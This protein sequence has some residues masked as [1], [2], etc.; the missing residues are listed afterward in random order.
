M[1]GNKKT[2]KEILEI[3]KQIDFMESELQ[4]LRKIVHQGQKVI[5]LVPVDA[6]TTYID[7]LT[8]DTGVAGKRIGSQTQA[9]FIHA[10]TEKEISKE[11]FRRGP[12]N[13]HVSRGW[14]WLVCRV[15]TKHIV[16]VPNNAMVD[17]DFTYWLTRQLVYS[18]KHV[19][20]TDCVWWGK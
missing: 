7:L 13:S 16:N 9:I 5:K 4:K 2:D 1:F 8:P 19:F 11:Q 14:K 15:E 3:S 12:Q 20:D 10:D 18:L 17:G 6:G